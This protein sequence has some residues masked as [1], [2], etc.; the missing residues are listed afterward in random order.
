MNK[1]WKQ[2]VKEASEVT[3]DRFVLQNDEVWY[4]INDTEPT[5]VCVADSDNKNTFIEEAK[6]I[7]YIYTI[8]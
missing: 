2:L 8:I 5:F 3:G 6:K 1:T 4:I 7:A